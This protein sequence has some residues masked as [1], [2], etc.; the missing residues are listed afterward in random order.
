[1]SQQLRDYPHLVGL[2]VPRHLM[3]AL[4]NIGMREIVGQKHNPTIMRWARELNMADIYKND[5]TA[6]CGLFA[7][8]TLHLADRLPKANTRWNYLRAAWYGTILNPVDKAAIGD[9]LIFRRQGGGHVGYYVG[10]DA[11]TYHVLGGNQSNEVNIMRL[12]KSRLT[13]IRRP[14]YTTFVPQSVV[15]RGGGN[16][17]TNEA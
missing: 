1:M 15:V 3:Y 13:H 11:T 9:L 2:T 12:E 10:E 5:E 17:S 8:Y 4:Q 7:A 14:N 6:W 16:I